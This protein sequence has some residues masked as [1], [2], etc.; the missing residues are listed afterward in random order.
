M[1][2]AKG[3]QADLTGSRINAGTPARTACRPMAPAVREGPEE[4][5]AGQAWGPPVK[6][7]RPVR[8]GDGEATE[9]LEATQ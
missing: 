6:T 8:T 5:A 1:K 2:L 7:G 3:I 4:R 9:G